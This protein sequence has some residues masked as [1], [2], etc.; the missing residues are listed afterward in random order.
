MPY[1]T[2]IFATGLKG[3]RGARIALGPCTYIEGPNATDKSSVADALHLAL[4]GYHPSGGRDGS[5]VRDLAVMARFAPQGAAQTEVRALLSVDAGELEIV[6]TWRAEERG[7]EGLTYKKGKA[8]VRTGSDLL[9]NEEARGYI[10]RTLG[11]PLFLDAQSWLTLPDD[12]RR[13]ALAPF[14]RCDW[15][16]AD[17]WR[18]AAA[19]AAGLL[20]EAGQPVPPLTEAALAAIFARPAAKTLL[21]GKKKPWCEPGTHAGELLAASG[22]DVQPW[23]SLAHAF[24]RAIGAQHQAE[25]EGLRKAVAELEGDPIDAHAVAELRAAHEAAGVHV[26]QT[27]AGY[28]EQIDRA[29]Q[30]KA[31]L[32]VRIEAA[33]QAAAQLAE[34]QAQIADLDGQ[35]AARAKVDALRAEIAGLAEEGWGE[36]APGSLVAAR[37]AVAEEEARLQAARS[38]LQ[39]A[40]AAQQEAAAELE[41]RRDAARVDERQADAAAAVE[42]GR[43]DQLGGKLGALAE[44][45][46]TLQ[47][48][49]QAAG[50][51]APACPLCGS[52]IDPGRVL[53]GLQA[54]IQAAEQE[55]DASRERHRQLLDAGLRRS[56][57]HV[58]A[59]QTQRQQVEQAKREQ[60][61]A[62]RCLETADQAHRRAEQALQSAQARLEILRA[63]LVAAEST[64][65]DGAQ[66]AVL[67]QQEADLAARSADARLTTTVLDA[68]LRRL[69]EL[70]KLAVE[71]AKGQ[72]TAALD[73]YIAGQ[74]RL[75]RKQNVATLQAECAQAEEDRASALAAAAALGP[76][77][78]LG[79]LLDQGK[80]PLVDAV[81]RCLGPLQLGRADLRLLDNRGADICQLG[82]WLADGSWAETT[83]SGG[84]SA[85]V[86]AGLQL[87]LQH[88][89]GA[90]Y[91]LVVIDG[92]EAVDELTGRR[93]R[94]LGQLRSLHEQG[95]VDQVLVTCCA[96]TPPAALAGWTVI[97][98]GAAA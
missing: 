67:R 28:Q 19:L 98:T 69:R 5:P 1:C 46:A 85:I 62:E 78:L 4:L 71:T 87:G 58:A 63:R 18:E 59:V 12:R 95:L 53:P 54:T 70:Q 6:R 51:G 20:D 40:Q 96:S 9:H 16:A 45:L 57:E 47:A 17:V 68:E 43:V 64:G 36:P 49:I 52:E 23:L 27:A 7:E 25:I 37:A 39:V 10:E 33:Q 14:L 50:W 3:Q 79:R 60:A 38:A 42:Q 88:L 81:N 97:R 72:Q 35:L 26:E 11:R 91:K 8:T 15:T 22:L 55:R 92:A 34:V 2:A 74:R 93:S 84:E 90:P 75:E 41:R 65:A 83:L 86:A 94:L 32:V 48:A 56:A 29:R 61:A 80:A 66:L 31:A 21:D 89:G 30:E 77:G 44:Q 82:L 13:A 73:A 24:C 76:R